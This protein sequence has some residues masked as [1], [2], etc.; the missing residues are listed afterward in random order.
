MTDVIE[1]VLSGKIT[2][3]KTVCAVLR[4]AVKLGYLVKK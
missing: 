3:G 1:D 2:D 4:A